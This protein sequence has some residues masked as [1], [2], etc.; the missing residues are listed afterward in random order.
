[1][2]TIREFWQRDRKHKNN[3]VGILDLKSII[4]E[5]KNSLEGFNT[6]QI[7]QKKEQANL[8]ARNWVWPNHTK[9]Y[10]DWNIAQLNGL[11]SYINK[12]C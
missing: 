7:K 10:V 2:W 5:L 11:V 9:Q 8:L 6:D 1:M 3:K 12:D 4:S